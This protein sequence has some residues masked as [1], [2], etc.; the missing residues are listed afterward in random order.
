MLNK[1][2]LVIVSV[3]ALYS[4]FILVSDINTVYDNI[5]NFK[6]EFLPIIF[7]LIF[8]GWFLLFL[9]WNLLLKNSNI[10][11]P[12][13]DSFLIYYS[14]FAFSFIPGEVG[15]LVKSKIL[16]NKFNIPIT[17]TSPIVISEFIYT[18]IGLVFL[19]LFL[20]GL[21]FEY[22][23]YIGGIFS[24]FLFIMFFMINSKNVFRIFLRIASKIKFISSYATSFEN[25]FDN[26][27]KSTSGKVAV[28]STLLSISH[29]LIESSAVFLIIYAYGIE[30]VFI[31]DIIPMYCTSIL[32]GFVSFLP[33]GLGVVEGAFSAFLNLRGIEL[34][35][36]LPLVIIIRLITNWFGILLGAFTLKK[37]GGLTSR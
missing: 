10:H 14:S 30:T 5:S 1:I 20:G 29:L 12:F 37:Y 16:K 15:S 36:A 25:S 18:G 17:K 34:A 27:K 4:A 23:L 3:I 13:K 32:L 31:L 11:I 35:V 7:P 28:Y 26:I 9:R 8:F 6:I 2:I 33:L 19:S 24:I 22:G 21:Y